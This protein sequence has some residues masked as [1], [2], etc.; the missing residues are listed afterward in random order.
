MQRIWNARGPLP[1]ETLAQRCMNQNCVA[2]EILLNGTKEV[3]S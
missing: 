2:W 3:K 1:T